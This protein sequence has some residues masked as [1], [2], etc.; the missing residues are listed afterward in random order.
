MILF[1]LCQTMP[2]S[3]EKMNESEMKVP[4]AVGEVSVRTLSCQGCGAVVTPSGAETLKC[5]RCGAS[6]AVP[7][8]Y[9]AAREAELS[10]AARRE[11]AA[12]LFKRLGRPPGL[13]LRLWGKA[14]GW[15]IFLLWPVALTVEALF[16]SKWLDRVGWYFHSNLNETLRPSE[17][18]ALLAAMM[19]VTLAVPL[20]VGI[21]G[22]RRT[23]ARRMIQAALSAKPPARP[24]GLSRCRSC[25]A[26]LKVEPGALGATCGYCEADNLVA[27][28]ESWVSEVRG[29][30]KSLGKSIEGAVA[31]DRKT[32]ART[33][34]SMFVQLSLLFLLVPLLYFIGKT[35]D[36]NRSRLP[37]DWKTAIET[38]VRVI[39]LDTAHAPSY[40]RVRGCEL[41]ECS[42]KSSFVALRYNDLA[43]TVNYGRFPSEVEGLLIEHSASSDPIFGYPWEEVTE[44]QV[45]LPPNRRA[46]E[47][48]A[49]R[50][51]WY[52]ID[53]IC[54]YP[55]EGC[56][57]V[58]Q[59]TNHVI[60][61]AAG[62]E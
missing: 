25:G 21:Y 51:G 56:R 10:V 4:S 60:V 29:R 40:L 24:D 31:E 23:N 59:N 28:P 46:V 41:P 34:R 37:P 5:S 1:P 48:R 54:A 22:K 39:P 6:V 45:I 52:K 14:S 17:F 19:Y 44:N 8:D 16:M 20:V 35:D 13:L 12:R 50:S 32:R 30:A 33:R 9:R 7:H 27:V 38:D 62:R 47:F 36:N 58:L 49:P 53:V 43:Q 11:E 42:Y 55:S 18:W 15:A 26:A 3:V 2:E 57:Q 61:S